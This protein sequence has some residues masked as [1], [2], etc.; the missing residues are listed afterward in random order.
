MSVNNTTLFD[1]M[2]KIFYKVDSLPEVEKEEIYSRCQ[3][4]ILSLDS[5]VEEKFSFLDKQKRKL[6]YNSLHYLNITSLSSYIDNEDEYNCLLV[7]VYLDRYVDFESSM[8]DFFATCKCFQKDVY[9]FQSLNIN[10][11]GILLPR[12]IPLWA[13][14]SGINRK[15]CNAKPFSLIKNYIWCPDSGNILVSHIYVDIN[16]LGK[17]DIQEPFRIVC[18]PLI[19]KCPY[20]ADF[21]NENGINY[22]YINDYFNEIQEV[23]ISRIEKTI[24]YAKEENAAIVLFPEMMISH[25]TQGAITRI[26]KDDWTRLYPKIIFFPSSEY[27]VDDKWKNEIIVTNDSGDLNIINS[28]DININI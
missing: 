19:D 12:F 21:G 7:L 22:F 5:I 6:T 1:I 9:S 25:E 11:M 24:N 2:A 16:P 10:G 8:K 27:Q 26:I 28:V 23:V 14:H 3:S 17:M 20:K 15:W 4:N 13:K 18:S